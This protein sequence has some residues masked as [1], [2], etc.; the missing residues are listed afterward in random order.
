MNCEYPPTRLIDF[1][2]HELLISEAAIALALSRCT[3]HTDPFPMILW[4]YGFISLDQLNQI[5]DWLNDQAQMAIEILL[6]T[7]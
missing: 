7:V 5:F 1:L 4:Q 3:L 2:Q 6:E